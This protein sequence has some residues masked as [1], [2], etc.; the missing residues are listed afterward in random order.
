MVTQ[1][2]VWFGGEIKVEPAELLVIRTN[3]QVISSRMNVE[4]RDPPETGHKCL[5]KLLSDEIVQADV[6]LGLHSIKH[7]PMNRNVSGG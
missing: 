3:D 2:L 4:R 5:E 1:R 7:I 6:S